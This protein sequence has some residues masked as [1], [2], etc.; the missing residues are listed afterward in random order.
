[1][2]DSWFYLPNTVWVLDARGAFPLDS[3][4]FSL[5]LDGVSAHAGFQ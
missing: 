3:R 2:P 5:E 4:D 1:M